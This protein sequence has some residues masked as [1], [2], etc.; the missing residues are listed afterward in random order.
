MRLRGP[1]RPSRS[2]HDNEGGQRSRLPAKL[3][4]LW[5]RLRCMSPAE[6]LHRVERAAQAQAE[7][8]GILGR[9]AVPAPDLA[10]AAPQWIRDTPSFDPAPYIESAERILDG[11]MDVFALRD[12]PVGAPPKWN[13]CPRT[14]IEAPLAFGKTLDYR[15]AALVGDIKYL[16]EPNRHLHLVTLAQAYKLTGEARYF[17]QLREQLLSWFDACPYPYGANWSSALEAGMRLIN[18]SIAWQLL[19]GVQASVFGDM[20]GEWLRQRWLESIFRHAQ[21]VKGYFSLHSSANN[22]LIGEA[23]GLFIAS[24]TWPHWHEACDWMAESKSIL[25]RELVLQNTADGV[26]RE[27]ASAYQQFELDLL[28]LCVLA[29]RGSGQV[30][31]E[32]FVRRFES[33]FE[34]LAAIMDAGGNVPM[35][36]D[37]DDGYAVRLSQEE[38]FCPYR[39]LLATGAV[40]FKRA[41][42]KAKARTLDDKT[43]WLLGTDAQRSFE[44]LPSQRA[45]AALRREFPEGGYYILGADFDTEREIRLLADAGPLGYQRIAAHGHADALAFTLSLGGTEF[46]IDPG[47]YAYHTQ[48]AWRTYFRGTS[49]H[50]T[51]RVDGRDQSEPGGNFMWLRKANAACTGWLTSEREDVFEGWH[52]GYRALSDPVIHRRRITLIKRA[53][54]IVIEDRLEMSGRHEIELFFHCDERCAIESSELGFRLRRGERILALRLPDLPGAGWEFIRGST[55]PI[56]GW[57]SRRFDERAPTTTIRWRARLE[58]AALLRT[59]LRCT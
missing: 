38:D 58:G 22:H 28:L 49:A 34:Y 8:A 24:M 43:R 20:A 6:V 11:R 32:G 33:M 1:L 13:R 9:G 47:T 3:R 35:I 10:A 12:A 41:D 26:N 25:E 42:F 21:F 56:L 19:G 53:R 46:L 2:P 48:D 37:S 18:W 59:E 36:G 50:N 31:S 54:R 16:W 4:W 39:S 51:L 5:N 45:G 40:L 30:F 7:R 55:R 29:A 27:Q 44:A 15:D 14:G 57:V 17:D 23:A 52:D